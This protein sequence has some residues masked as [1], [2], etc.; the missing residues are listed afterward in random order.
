MAVPLATPV[1]APRRRSWAPLGLRITFSGLLALAVILLVG[2]AALNSEANLLFLLFGISVGVVVYSLFAP[3]V[4]VRR[5]TAE[6]IIPAGVVAGRPFSI[7]YGVRNQRRWLRSWSLAIGEIPLGRSGVRFPAGFLESL[8]P[9]E[10]RRLQL[11]GWCPRRGRL[12]LRGIRLVSRFPFGLFSCTVDLDLPGELV[13]YPAVGRFRRDLWRD[14]RASDTQTTRNVRHHRGDNE[15]FYGVREYRPGDNLRSVH[16]RRSA[17][18]GHLVVRESMPV[19]TQQLVVLVDPWP[20]PSGRA[21]GNGPAAEMRGKARSRSVASSGSSPDAAPA[22]DPAGSTGGGSLVH[23]ALRRLRPWMSWR[24]EPSPWAEDS[25]ERAISLAATAVCEALER[26]HRVGLIARAA[27]PVV[28]SPAGGR[29]QRQRLLHELAM[30]KPGAHEE[31]DELVSSIRWAGGW[32]GRCLL[33]ATWFNRSHE[34]VV[35]FL[36]ARTESAMALSC[37]QETLDNLFELSPER[38]VESPPAVE[39]KTAIAGGVA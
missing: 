15:E 10:E 14:R 1:V 32:S 38:P 26:G 5:V 24:S 34:H 17:H 37:E 21:A 22:G 35:R 30:L 39:R 9:G 28:I 19:R 6:R 18:T 29:A 31:M 7:G 23:R 20:D 27:R 3:V 8:D 13:I 4:M 2:L 33:C 25:V 36:T 11:T 12:Q 16:W